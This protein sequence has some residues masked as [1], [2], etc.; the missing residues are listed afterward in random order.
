MGRGDQFSIQALGSENMV[1]VR[2]QYA[3]MLGNTGTRLSIYGSSLQYQLGGSFANLQAEGDGRMIGGIL[4]YTLLRQEAQSLYGSLTLENRLNQSSQLGVMNRLR[5]INTGIL[6]L[7][8]DRQDNWVIKARN[9]SAMHLSFG[10][11]NIDLAEDKKAD[12]QS[13]RAQGN[14]LKFNYSF[15]RT[16]YLSNVWQLSMTFNGQWADKN[17]DSSQMFALGGPNGVRAYPVNEGM[18]DSGWLVNLELQRYLGYGLHGLLFA[19]TGGIKVNQQL[20]SGAAGS[21]NTYQL[22]GV[23]IGLRWSDQKQ[24]QA[25]ALVGLP[26][27]SN[28]GRDHFNHNADGTR[29]GDPAGWL[30]LTRFFQL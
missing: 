5:D 29:A 24:W 2:G 19:D 10:D 30:T 25:S 1:N 9:S 8:G 7:Y 22:S 15:H 17:L 18:G 27:T 12:A 11:L 21:P 6:S 20:W 23:G 4:S 16:E 26:I 28:P 13:A 14:F 3:F